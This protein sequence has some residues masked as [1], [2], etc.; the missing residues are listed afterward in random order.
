MR[1]SKNLLLILVSVGLLGTWVYHLYDK[2]IYSTQKA[3]V[4]VKDTLATQEA[5][6]DSLRKLFDEKIY[7]LDTIKVQEDSLKG[8]LDS[9]RSKIFNLRKQI[10]DILKNRNATK[11][12]LKTARDLIAEY[13]QRVEEMK[14]QNSDLET[15]RARLNGVL[16]QLNDEMKG[17]QQSIQ[18]ITEENKELTETINQ[19]ST[20][21]ASDMRLSAVTTKAGSKEVEA[22]TAKK[23]NKFIFSFTLQNNI[24]KD[25]YY[26]IYVV[27]TQPGN[28]V[29]QTDV[30]GADYF[31]SKTEGTKPYTAK[32][33]FEYNRG[34]RKKIVYTL[35]PDNFLPGTYTMQVYQNG[36]SLGETSKHLN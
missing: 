20:F 36:I 2:S 14:A 28:K 25:S 26:D 1:D 11:T 10:T 9:T 17:L 21:I 5:I 22:A 23:A 30:W 24:A 19:A 6:K 29:L 18:K 32:I 16:T 4:L 34:E 12:D 15:E 35:Q 33:H 7:E 27:I 8:S 31:V 3:T 13:K